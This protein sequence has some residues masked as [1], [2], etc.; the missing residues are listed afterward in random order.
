MRRR[1]VGFTLVELLVVIGIIA[2]L[3][4]ILLPA[5]SKARE[6]ANQVKCL[7]N[8]KQMG[9]AMIMYT[10]D[11]KGSFPRTAPNTPTVGW[12]WVHWKSGEKLEDSAMNTYFGTLTPQMLICPTDQREG[13]KAAG[14]LANGYPFSYVM[15]GR[16][17]PKNPDGTYFQ[18]S[19][20]YDAH[21]TATK[22]TEVRNTA[23]KV[24]FYE[25]DELT[26]DDGHGVL[27]TPNLLA[28][29]HDRANQRSATITQ[30]LCT[31]GALSGSIQIPASEAKG[32]AGFC[33]GHASI[34]S[35]A[36]IHHPK[37]YEPK[38]ENNGIP[39]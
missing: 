27:R 21:D 38:W 24:L 39:Q 36:F 25:E 2:L 20:N 30:Q 5:L 4:S 29:R 18:D 26:I 33:D 32:A 22:L 6:S 1:P 19:S 14:G 9:T 35:R 13:H 10:N 23:D 31:K 16:L 37:H 8:M 28:I 15:N 11:W 3:I 7:S 34:V 17:S 12:D